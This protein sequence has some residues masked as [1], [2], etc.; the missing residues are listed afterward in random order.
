MDFVGGNEFD[1]DHLMVSLIRHADGK[2]V[3]ESDAI[4][5]D[6]RDFR[7]AQLTRSS[8]DPTPVAV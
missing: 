8:V 6:Y 3:K 5:P 1:H 4:P 2:L 7:L